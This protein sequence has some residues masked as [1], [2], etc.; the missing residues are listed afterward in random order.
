MITGRL[1]SADELERIAEIDRSEVIERIYYAEPDG[2]VARAERYDMRGWPSGNVDGIVA[3]LRTCHAQGGWIYGL[4]GGDRLI[5]VAAVDTRRFGPRQ[6]MLQLLLMH[7][8]Q[9][10]RDQ[11]LGT[12]L[13]GAACAQA[14]ARGARRLYVSAT[15]SEHTVHF[16]L[17]RGCC[18]TDEPDPE[19]FA[20][21]PEDIHMVCD[22]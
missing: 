15:P 11:G 5:G 2:L 4:F 22:L 9:P 21:E 1:L 10:Y 18:V 6:E 12:R 7:V 3:D 14:R 17:A 8:S 20:L 13:F 16:Y 19:L